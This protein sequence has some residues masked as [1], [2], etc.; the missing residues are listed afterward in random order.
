MPFTCTPVTVT[1]SSQ[2]SWANCRRCSKM[3]FL[4][5]LL[6]VFSENTPASPQTDITAGR[7]LVNTPRKLQGIVIKMTLIQRTNIS[8]SKM[9][10]YGHLKVRGK[11]YSKLIRVAVSI[12]AGSKSEESCPTVLPS[13]SKKFNLGVKEPMGTLQETIRGKSKPGQGGTILSPRG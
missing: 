10:R 7:L 13:C 3:T 6:S 1:Q 2:Q 5:D 12:Y 11:W 4:G 9:E 8:S